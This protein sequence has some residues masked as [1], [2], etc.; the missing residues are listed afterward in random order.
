MFRLPPCL[1]LPWRVQ[2][3]SQTFYGL[4][5]N[6]LLQSIL[7]SGWQARGCHPSVFWITHCSEM[8]RWAAKTMQGASERWGHFWLRLW[9]LV[10]NICAAWLPAWG[11]KLTLYYPSSYA[12]FCALQQPIIYRKKNNIIIKKDG[13]VLESFVSS[14]SCR[15]LGLRPFL[16]WELVIVEAEDCDL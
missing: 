4:H 14:N 1:G 13:F 8:V 7:L 16:Q 11:C 6:D 3:L 12:L 5:L 2:I 15:S 9:A 10:G